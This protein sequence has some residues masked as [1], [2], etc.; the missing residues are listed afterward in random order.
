M[1][2][3]V[4]EDFGFFN[5]IAPEVLG[6]VAAKASLTSFQAGDVIFRLGQPSDHFY[7]L[8]AGA[9]SLNLVV[10]DR[11]L[12]TDIKYEEAIKADIVDREKKIVVA[13]VE[14]G[15]VFGWSALT[16]ERK[17][18]VTAQCK[19]A[20][21]VVSIPATHLT[22]LFKED[23]LFGYTIMKRLC[24]IVSAR[25]QART[26]KLIEAWVEAFGTTEI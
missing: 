6:R 3:I 8:A 4:L 25:L 19:S 15:Q 23:P 24:D 17:R 9:V 21:Q 1:A 18:T 7:G 12:E 5:G 13:S 14:P 22:A 11:V 10:T 2:E 16:G 26:D 20:S